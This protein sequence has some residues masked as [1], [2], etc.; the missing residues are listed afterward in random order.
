L[1]GS[2]YSATPIVVPNTKEEKEGVRLP[3]VR[4]SEPLITENYSF[5]IGCYKNDT[6][7]ITSTALLTVAEQNRCTPKLE[8]KDEGLEYDYYKTHDNS[9]SLNPQSTL[10]MTYNCKNKYYSNSDIPDSEMFAEADSI[11]ILPYCE[12]K[13]TNCIFVA[14]DDSSLDSGRELVNLKFEIKPDHEIEMD[15][16]DTKS[17]TSTELLTV[18]EQNRYTPELESIDEEFKDICFKTHYNSFQH[19][20]QVKNV[21][22]VENE[23]VIISSR[24]VVSEHNEIENNQ[25]KLNSHVICS[26]AKDRSSMDLKEGN[27]CILYKIHTI[28]KTVDLNDTDNSMNSFI[29]VV[30][31]PNAIVNPVSIKRKQSNIICDTISNKNVKKERLNEKYRFYEKNS[32]DDKTTKSYKNSV[33]K[34]RSCMDLKEGN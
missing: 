29:A 23:S 10:K 33:A 7:L 12:I 1:Q 18:A 5:K 34:D 20:C 27:Q 19:F 22:I 25:S 16:N 6:K 11:E 26:A 17:I 15:K 2:A 21:E 9:L 28:H 8:S 13:E 3:K 24:Q 30:E 4:F 31:P 32:T 14:S